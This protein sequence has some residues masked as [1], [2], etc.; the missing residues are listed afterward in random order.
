MSTPAL[1]P[2]GLVALAA[3]PA[4]TFAG[5]TYWNTVLKAVRTYDGAAW[6]GGSASTQR[7]F[8]FFSG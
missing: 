6:T 4:G 8:A 5:E 7:T 2:I 1:V 3:D